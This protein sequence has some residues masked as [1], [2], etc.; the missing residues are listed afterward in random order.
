M[1]RPLPA[2]LPAL[3]AAAC[4]ATLHAAGRWELVFFHDVIDSELTIVDLCFPSPRRGVAVGYLSEKGKTRP[5]A[6]VTSDGGRTWNFVRLKEAPRSVF[7]LNET[8]GWMVTEKGIWQ[9]VES[10]R[11]WRKLADLRGLLRVH[12]LDENRGWAVGAEKAIHETTDG[13]R[14]WSR[15]AV[16]DQPQTTKQYTTYSWIDFADSRHGSIIGYSAPP[17]PGASR[18]PDWMDPE[19]AERRRQWPTLSIVIQTADGGRTWKPSTTSM[20]GRITRFRMSPSGQGLTLVEFQD[21][22]DWPSEVYRVDLSTNRT[23]RVYREKNRAVKDV[24]LTAGGQGFMAAIETSGKLQQSPIPGRL[25][26]LH[27]RDLVTWEEMEVDY[28]A[29][30][31]RAVLASDG[32]GHVWAATDTGM[33]L[34]L[35]KD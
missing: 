32:A 29:T 18:F 17:R 15:L 8:V 5:Q 25:V 6:L 22:F 19:R 7:F 23:D 14:H 1:F 10:G 13:G 9:S 33:I 28:R 31:R 24:L 34:R 12:F 2:L 21:A 11:S 4:S 20:F 3:L 26:I 16:A 35:L 27:S 30:A